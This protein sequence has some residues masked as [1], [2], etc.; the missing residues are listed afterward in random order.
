MTVVLVALCVLVALA[1]LVVVLDHLRFGIET[2]SISTHDL[3][4]IAPPIASESVGSG[5]SAYHSGHSS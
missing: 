3:P 2:F 1:L 4:N 5:R